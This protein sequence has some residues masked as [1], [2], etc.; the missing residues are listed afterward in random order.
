MIA[1]EKPPLRIAKSASSR[2]TLRD[3]EVRAVR[4]LA[5]L[6]LA[7]RLRAV[8]VRRLEGVAAGAALVEELGPA[9]RG[10]VALRDLDL[11]AAAGEERGGEQRRR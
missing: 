10:L 8:G 1:P 11:A 5:A 4:A 7:L 9:V 6:E 2:A 3:V